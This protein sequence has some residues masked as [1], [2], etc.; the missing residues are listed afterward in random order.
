[1]TDCTIVKRTTGWAYADGRA[2]RLRKW[3]PVCP[4]CGPVTSI[5]RIWPDWDP[6]YVPTYK[7]RKLAKDALH[8]HRT[9]AGH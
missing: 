9:A 2:R 3:C 7:S 5:S 1:M 6:P 8:K 4:V